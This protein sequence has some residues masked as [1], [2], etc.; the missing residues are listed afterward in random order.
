MPKAKVISLNKGDQENQP[1]EVNDQPVEVSTEPVPEETQEQLREMVKADSKFGPVIDEKLRTLEGEELL[2]YL[3][4]IP[5]KYVTSMMIDHIGY[6]KK[7]AIRNAGA[8]VKKR[9]DTLKEEA[10]KI[11]AF[12]NKPALR[13]EVDTAISNA[14]TILVDM[15]RQMADSIDELNNRISELEIKLGTAEPVESTEP[16]EIQE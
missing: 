15:I 4:S 3:E 2:A 8:E 1:I 7:S 12:S 14:Y 10:G 5:D 9:F 13:R 6:E 11:Y 16:V